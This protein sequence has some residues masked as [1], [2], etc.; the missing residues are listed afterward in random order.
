[1]QEEGWL[2]AAKKGVTPQKQ[3]DN[4][5]LPPHLPTPISLLSGSISERA[6]REYVLP[7]GGGSLGDVQLVLHCTTT[8]EPKISV[9]KQDCC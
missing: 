7:N 6:K 5:L 9:V 4:T 2:I 3:L 1:M 8:R